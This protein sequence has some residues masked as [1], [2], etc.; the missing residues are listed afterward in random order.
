MYNVNINV[1][2]LNKYIYICK[3]KIFITYVYIEDFYIYIFTILYIYIIF[4]FI[5]L[6]RQAMGSRREGG[7]MKRTVAGVLRVSAEAAISEFLGD[8][9]GQQP[10]KLLGLKL[11][12]ALALPVSSA[13]MEI[14]I[15]L[16]LVWYVCGLICCLMERMDQP[17]MWDCMNFLAKPMRLFMALGLPMFFCCCGGFRTMFSLV[18]AWQFIR[19]LFGVWQR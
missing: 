18:S 7:S 19:F 10:E 15:G 12:D 17:V 3:Y 13:V 1:F 5:E 2:I 11:S 14:S 8:V 16:T 9:L 4:I 6:D